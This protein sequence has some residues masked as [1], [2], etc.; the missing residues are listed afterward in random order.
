MCW[1]IISLK[2]RDYLDH[3]RWWWRNGVLLGT[4]RRTNLRSSWEIERNSHTFR[5]R[6]RSRGSSGAGHLHTRIIL[7]ELQTSWPRSDWAGCSAQLNSIIMRTIH[8]RCSLP[9]S[10]V[11]EFRFTCAVRHISV[12]EQISNTRKDNS[13]GQQNECDG[14]VLLHWGGR[15]RGRRGW[16][17]DCRTHCST[18]L[19]ITWVSHTP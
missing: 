7:R 13:Y 9:G 10:F 8:R 17:W 2:Y 18:A 3:L 1:A 14:E 12:V 16:K 4:R 11:A 5:T 19:C 15:P 6:D